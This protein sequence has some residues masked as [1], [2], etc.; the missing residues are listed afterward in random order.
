MNGALHAY[1]LLVIGTGPGGQKAALAAAKAGHRV[2]I[3]EKKAVVGGACINTG[4]IPSKSLREAVLYLSGWREHTF[5]GASYAVKHDITVND[6][7][8]RATYVIQ[9]EL[10]VIQH[11]MFRN[12]V[13]LI[14]ADASFADPHT[15]NL[16]M[17]DGSGTRQATA[18]FIVIAT[19]T[20]AAQPR[21]C[22]VDNQS[23]FTSDAILQLDRI[24]RTLAVVGAGVIGC[25]YASMFAAL[26]TRVTLIDARPSLLP[27][28]DEEISDALAFHLRENNVTLRLN[29]T[30][31]H[32]ER[33][34]DGHVTTHLKSGKH[35]TTEKALYSVGR[36]G[37][38][39][40]LNLAAAGL[41]PDE[42]GRMVVNEHYQ[43]SVPHIYAVGDVIGFPSL[44]STSMEQGRLAA[45]HAFGL[46]A[47]SVPAL[48]PYGIY[49][50]PEIS[51]VGKTEAELTKDNIPYEVGKASYKE[52]ARGQIIGDQVGVLKLLF[53]SDTRQLL[54][55]HII[56][57][58]ASELVHIG[59]AVLAF[60]GTTDYF[61]NT[62]F[63][64]PTLAECYKVATFDALNRIQ[65]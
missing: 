45:S 44:A 34:D 27:F 15:V 21:D 35:L 14:R 49:T 46:N 40:A 11:Q 7:L 2:A 6:L 62:V 30:V 13:D 47:H 39:A 56:G 65:G 53:H 23:I 26:G 36:V 5:Y 24:P 55:V 10:D 25:E 52:I 20:D 4:T 37:A 31:E 16:A 59:Q 28:V 29:E 58:G 17:L 42:R 1:D 51:M 8:V 57:E 3:I 18:K 48:F 33:N 43:T 38:T 60:N 50:I 12:G 61:V 9:H 32:L 64:Y 19:G 54:G 41:V 63:N 22:T